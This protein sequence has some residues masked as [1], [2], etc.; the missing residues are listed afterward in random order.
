MEAPVSCSVHVPIRVL[1][2]FV[3]STATTRLDVSPVLGN[4]LLAFESIHA[5]PLGIDVELGGLPKKFAFRQAG[6]DGGE[7]ANDLHVTSPDLI[8]QG[9]T[10]RRP[11]GRFDL[12]PHSSVC[13]RPVPYG[14]DCR[15][16]LGVRAGSPSG[17]SVAA[18]GAAMS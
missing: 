5:L 2:G 8:R 10:L 6:T 11:E 17:G 1:G 16:H 4:S 12:S 14:W 3:V 13:P 9:H 15:A 18:T 7:T